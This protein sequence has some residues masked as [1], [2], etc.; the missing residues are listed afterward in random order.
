MTPSNVTGALAAGIPGGLALTVTKGGS[1]SGTVTSAPAVVD[2][3]AT[4]T[5]TFESGTTVALSASVAAGSTFGGWSGACTGT[6]DCTVTMDAAKGVTATFS[7]LAAIPHFANIATRSQVLT[8]EN[9]MIAGFIIQGEGPQTVY[10][11]A[12]GPSLVPLGVVNVLPDPVLQ[13]FSG[14]TVIGINDDWQSSPDAAAI[15]ASGFAPSD[16]RESVIL[17][18]LPPGP[19]TAIVSGKAGGTGVAIIEVFAQ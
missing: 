10:V 3:G 7:P 11:R 1:G 15:Q 13:L 18:T 2:C 12:R 4:C 9:V 17:A 14:Q 6:G 8:G 16:S 5:A 19:Y